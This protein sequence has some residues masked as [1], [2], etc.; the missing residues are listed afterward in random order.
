MRHPTL[1]LSTLAT[2]VALAWP[3]H[4]SQAAVPPGAAAEIVGLQGPGDQ[5]TAAA[6]DWK[7]ARQAQ[8][9]AAGD[10]VRTREAARMALLFADDTQLRLHQNTVLQVKAVATPTQPMT[11]LMLSAGRAWTQTRRPDGSRLTLETPAA[12]AAIRGTDWDIE[13]AGDGRT[14]ITVLSGTV[15]FGNAQ[16]QVVVAA[17]EAAYADIGQAPVKMVLSQPR[18]RIQWVNALRADP[19]PHLAA[20][21]STDGGMPAVL[22]P[23]Q[24]A[25]AARDG[26][27]A[28]AALAAARGQAP[29]G[30]VATMESAVALQAGD[31]QSAR[32]VLAGQAE[33]RPPVLAAQLMLS[34]L[35][36]LEG[37]GPAAVRTLQAALARHWPGHPALLAQLAR[38]QLLTDRVPEAAATLGPAP[39][40]DPGLALVRAELARRQGD[41]PGAIAAYTEATRLAPQD[42]RAWQGLGSAHVERE[43]TG[44][45]RAAL[46]R[47]LSLD[48]QVPGAQGERGTL[49]TF[50][51]QFT[52]AGQAFETA[53]RDNPADYV[54][55][56]GQGLMRLKQGQPQAAL[57]DFLRAGVMEPRYAR[58]KVWTAVAYYQLG[59][60]PD[61]LATLRQASA[62]D[63]KDPLPYLLLAQ[64]QTDLFQPGDAVESARAAVQRMPY[65]KSLNQVANDQK[66]SANLGASL[67]FFGMEDWA[68]EL[69]QKSF[70]PY[71]GGSHLFLA[72][73]YRGEFNKNSALFQGFLTDPMAFGASQLHS[74]LLQRPGSHGAMGLLLDRDFYR[75]HAPSLTLNGMDNSR[76]PVSWFFKAQGARAKRSPIDVGVFNVPAFHDPSG[77]ADIG[78]DVLTFGLGLQPHERLNLFA[79]ANQYDVSLQGRNRLD[80]WGDGS[81]VRQTT[82]DNRA[83][84]G[85][86][87]LSYRWSPVE[88][89]WLKI[90]RSRERNRADN[91][92]TVFLFEPLAALGGLKASPEKAFTDLQLRHSV[93]PQTGQRWSVALEH[94]AEKQSSEVSG[95]GPL[96]RQDSG[97]VP[98]ILVFAGVN[99]IDRRYTG[100]TLAGSQQ[101]SPQLLLD[102][103]LG[104]Q[105]IRHRVRGGNAVGLLIR[106]VSESTQAR[107]NDTERVATP[108]FGVVF[109]PVAGTTLRMAYQDWL[110]PLSA[111]TLTSVE[112]AGIPVEDRMVEAGGRHRRTVAQLG[113][114]VDGHTFLNLRADHLR[115]RNPGVLGVDLRT[116][117]MPFL[118]EMRN[119]QLINLSTTDV[120]EGTPGFEEGTLQALGAGVNRMFSR[121][122]SGYAK[123][124]YQH[125]SSQ[126]LDSTSNRMVRGLRIPYIPRHTAVVGATWAS[127]QRV[128][129]SARAVY[130]SERFEDKQNLTR[131]P[132]GWS[133]DLVGY[134]ETQ[135]KHWVLGAG[136]L[137]LFGDRTPRQTVRYV[138]D[139]RY[140]F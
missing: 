76:L 104:L 66:G 115:V 112:T 42:A 23:V 12:T 46:G 108:R 17:N 139:A 65:L 36:L 106:D 73:R 121:Q 83:R 124:L 33:A 29:A 59:R 28:A 32:A 114:E 27:A 95:Y 130:R 3:W 49:E 98:D 71:W 9:L 92:P 116:P 30:W 26:T 134:W 2:L 20:Q 79:Y 94:V 15:E 56:T 6:A 4:A 105:Q 14:L 57:G 64:I 69:A 40:G 43:E 118:E 41:G 91:F 7:P 136:V 101:F 127:A 11:T 93:D 103:A 132:P 122:W 81:E 24:R 135:D 125:S 38:V 10:F 111:S 137:N 102:G 55:L 96:V 140:R 123:Y 109:T 45:A 31:L 74:S 80:L 126:Y 35:Q 21:G 138:I 70:S 97:A 117:S 37:D 77:T 129:L 113:M 13:V 84:L 44:P 128:Y 16:G 131:R 47:A 100:L 120:L 107:R 133:L 99:E 75:M 110:R 61:A 60:T 53:L 58:A 39:A 52:E 89:S 19:L 63:D 88:Q 25:L 22:Q 62:L 54:A 18:D 34:D 50:V 90:G 119:A 48:A 85:V 68:L 51:N 87:G 67:A 82:A 72:D 86:A 8:A 5:R 1:H 78:A